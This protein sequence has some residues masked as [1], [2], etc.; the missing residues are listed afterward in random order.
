MLA[1]LRLHD[2]PDQVQ[3]L[4]LVAGEER[5]AHRHLARR[6][7][8]PDA[9]AGRAHLRV[10]L[11]SMAGAPLPAPAG[12]LSSA[13]GAH[14]ALGNLAAGFVG[15]VPVLLDEVRLH[16]VVARLGPMDVPD[17]HA[18]MPFTWPA[19]PRVIC[20]WARTPP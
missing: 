19:F 18:V 17:L 1:L 5:T 11:R 14:G 16:G 13:F 12:E 20:A 15:V 7:P 9:A 3:D 4:V 6:V 2:I 8:V 10:R